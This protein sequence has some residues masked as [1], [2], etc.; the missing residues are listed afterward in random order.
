MV[1]NWYKNEVLQKI[2]SLKNTSF[3][4]VKIDCVFGK[5]KY[6]L[7]LLTR[8]KENDEAIISLLSNWR[9]KYN[10]W[11]P[12]QFKVTNKGTKKWFKEKLIEAEDRVLFM[13]KVRDKYIGHVGLYRF[14]FDKRICELDN[15]LRGKEG[16]KGIIT[17]AIKEMMDWGKSELGLKSFVLTTLLHNRRARRVYERLG[18]REYKRVPMIA[19]VSKG[20]I[21]W[22]KMPVDFQGKITR[23]NVYMKLMI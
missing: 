8:E 1:K 20:R 2:K 3:G 21:D 4:K 10:D 13:I 18:F 15:I 9:R 6:K 22:L 7:L 16:Y 11:F 23:F 19:K 12:A 17:Q 14:D 5:L